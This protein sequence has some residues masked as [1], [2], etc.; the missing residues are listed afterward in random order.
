[1]FLSRVQII[2]DRVYSDWFFFRSDLFGR[3]FS[4]PVLSDKRNLDPKITCK[5]LVRFR[6][7]YFW[8]GFGWNL[9]VQVK[10]LRSMHCIVIHSE[11]SNKIK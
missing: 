9:R 8:I 3:F 7:G 4:V 11:Q 1:M 6:I 5:F 10:M 2:S